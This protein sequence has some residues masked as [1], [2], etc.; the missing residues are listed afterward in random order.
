MIASALLA[1]V[2]P[3]AG[4]AQIFARAEALCRADAGALWGVSLC[5]PMMVADPNTREAIANR[6]APGSTAAGKL[7][8]FTLSPTTPISTAPAQFGG[9]L[10]A[11]IMWP[12]NTSYIPGV[13]PG[14]TR[15]VVLMHESFH[16]VQPRVGF[17]GY[18]GTGS[19]SGVAYLDA[20]AGRT[21]LRGELH[22]LR[23]ALYASGA[24][25]RRALHDALALRFYRHT[26][27][28]GAAEQEREQDIMEGLAEGTG[29]DAGLP[30]NRRIPFAVADAAFVE[31]QPS[32]ARAF[33]YA[34]GPAYTE[35]LDAARA[36][37]RR[38]VTPS[39]DLAQMTMH[40]YDLEVATPSASHAEAIIRHYGGTKI[41]S[42]EAART[43]RTIERAKKY[44]GELIAG[45]TIE[46]PMTKFSIKFNPRDIETLEPYGSVYHTLTITAIWGAIAVAG[47]DALISKDFRTLRLAAAADVKGKRVRGAGWTLDLA[48]GY[49]LVPDLE[50]K[51]S[52]TVAA[53]P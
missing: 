47:G 37:W 38:A 39:S 29:I 12:L 34:T 49:T 48:P 11:Q 52:F 50:K 6:A 18:A 43:A 40:A 8:R 28:A 24:Q 44:R 35:L 30:P 2:I 20:R 46:L 15:S 31:A 7:F 22:A 13:D 42:E 51:H 17:T 27:F 16:V 3:Q 4:A 33:A 26:L 21:W 5:V 25:R 14:D 41:E 53:K 1:L 10:W 19:I 9:R 32:F 36:R 45:S 23:A